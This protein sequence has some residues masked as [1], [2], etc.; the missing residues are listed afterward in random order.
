ML[1]V[2]VSW[3]VGYSDVLTNQVCNVLA[4]NSRVEDNKGYYE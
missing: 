3:N 1:E 4:L 2:H